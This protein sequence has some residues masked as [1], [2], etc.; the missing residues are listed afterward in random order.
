[1]N[2]GTTPRDSW[3][4]RLIYFNIVKRNYEIRGVKRVNENAYESGIAPIIAVQERPFFKKTENFCSGLVIPTGG[5]A[6]EKSRM[7]SIGH[8]EDDRS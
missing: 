7:T 4:T 2:A 3:R 8:G 6:C 1:M 5:C